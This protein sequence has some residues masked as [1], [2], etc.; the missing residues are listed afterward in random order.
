MEEVWGHP[1]I[2]ARGR[3]REVKT[4]AGPVAAL[5]PPA[6]LS[7]SEARMEA[8]PALGEHTDSVLTGLGY[9]PEEIARLRAEAVV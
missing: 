1:Q 6:T 9:S 4:P 2:A 5:L 8:V 3:W 7:T